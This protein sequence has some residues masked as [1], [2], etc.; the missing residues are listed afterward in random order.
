MTEDGV[1]GEGRCL[2]HRRL[3][4]HCSQVAKG[5]GELSES[6]LKISCPHQF[7]SVDRCGHTKE[8]SLDTWRMVMQHFLYDF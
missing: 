8:L 2:A 3:S 5:A 4:P 6:L 7:G 1:F